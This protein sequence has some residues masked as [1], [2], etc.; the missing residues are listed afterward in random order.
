MSIFNFYL[1]IFQHRAYAFT[2]REN[3]AFTY[4]SFILSLFLSLSC[5]SF[6]IQR[7]SIKYDEEDIISRSSR[8][9]RV[10]SRAIRT[11]ARIR[12]L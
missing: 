9:H 7:Y 12:D 1:I 2:Y 6:S 4:K 11:I 10:Y 8:M 3:E 5:L